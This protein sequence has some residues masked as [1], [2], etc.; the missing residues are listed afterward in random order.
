MFA[1][2]SATVLTTAEPPLDRVA[3]NLLFLGIQSYRIDIEGHT[4]DAPI[5]TAQ[6]PSNWELSTARA[7][8]V[9]RFIISR[10]VK[11]DRI[12]VIGFAETQPKVPNRDQAATPSPRTAPKTAAW[13]SASS[14]S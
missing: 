5:N 14:D 1:T 8:A 9:A 4:D 13:S 3:Q 10:G 6:F 12:T 2:G 11:A 7:S